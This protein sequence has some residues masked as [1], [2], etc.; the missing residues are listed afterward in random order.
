VG[1]CEKGRFRAEIGDFEPISAFGA[2][3]RLL[4]AISAKS[5]LKRPSVRLSGQYRL[6]GESLLLERL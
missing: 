6:Y 2:E 5:G 3:I 4:A 1:N